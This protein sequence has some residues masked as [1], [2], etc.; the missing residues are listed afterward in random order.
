M[1]SKIFYVL[2]WD[3]VL[4]LG[5]FLA[6]RHVEFNLLAIG[7]GFESICFNGTEMHK[8][9]RAVFT[10][11]KAESFRLVKP[12][13]G[14]VCLRHRVYLYCCSAMSRRLNH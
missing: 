2:E 4:G 13:N 8:Y 10:L 11:D 9:V 6:V 5:A 1:H 14:T 12:F 7:Q 3:Y